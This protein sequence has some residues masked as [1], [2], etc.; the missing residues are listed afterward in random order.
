MKEITL[1]VPDSMAQM[2]EDWATII[3]GIELVHRD[4]TGDNILDAMDIRMLQALAVLQ[5][6]G[7]IRFLYDYTWIM[8]AIG[9]NAIKGMSAFKSPQTFLDYLRH[10]G[11]KRVPCRSTISDKSEKVI[12]TYPNWT[13][14]DTNDPLESIRRKNVVA[15]L[16]SFLNRKK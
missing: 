11:M 16:I 15:Q 13:F 4:E 3:P 12:G 5:K 10:L 7:A 2:I 1:R 6:N 9:D 14:T 8:V